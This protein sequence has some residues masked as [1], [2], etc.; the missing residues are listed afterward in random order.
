METLLL[1]SVIAV[2]ISFMADSLIG[3]PFTLF[4]CLDYL[5]LSIYSIRVFSYS[6]L[7]FVFH[8]SLSK[9]HYLKIVNQNDCQ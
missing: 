5:R 7:Q 3:V 6:L 2:V 4:E 1:I 8:S 9:D